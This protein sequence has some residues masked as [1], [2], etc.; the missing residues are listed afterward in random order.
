MRTTSRYKIIQQDLLLLR[1]RAIFHRLIN[2][3]A[4]AH[5]Y[6]RKITGSPLLYDCRSNDRRGDDEAS[7]LPLIHRTSCR[8]IR[9]QDERVATDF[10]SDQLSRAKCGLAA[11]PD[12]STARQT[13]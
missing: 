8:A 2:T 11:G 9:F 12:S 7:K 3:R 1:P 10:G 6:C 13:P 4:G 5:T